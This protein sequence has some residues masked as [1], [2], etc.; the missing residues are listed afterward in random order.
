VENYS[1]MCLQSL[2]LAIQ[3]LFNTYFRTKK[4]LRG[5]MA[6]WVS[7]VETLVQRCKEACQWLVEY[8]SSEEGSTYLKPFLLECPTK[9]TRIAF[10]KMLE[11]TMANFF[12]HGGIPTHKCFDELLEFLLAMLNKD[13]ADNIKN[14]TQYFWVLSMYVQMGTKACSHMF[15]R[16]AFSRLVHFLLG[17][18]SSSTSVNGEQESG[19][20]RWSSIQARD[21]GP[22]HSTIATLILNCDVSPYRTEEPGNHTIYNPTTVVPQRYL[23]MSPEMQS[24]V[25]GTESARYIRE[26]VLALKEVSGSTTHLEDMILYTSF[27]NSTVS[28]SIIRNIMIQCASAPSNELKP[29]FGVLHDML[30]MEDPLQLKRL[31]TVID[32]TTD[33][34]GMLAVI[35]INHMNDS[36]RS[37][38]CIKFL[39]NLANKS[40]LAKDYLMQAPTK[41][42]WAVNWLKKKMTEYYWT[43]S[44]STV[45]SNEDSNS[46]SFQRTISAQDTLAEATAL[47]TEL[48]A[49]DQSDMETNGDS[50]FADDDDNKDEQTEEVEKL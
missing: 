20:R 39:V 35:K 13:V 44:S 41:W 25:F 27:C 37:Y 17:N 8:L 24:Y 48:E 47:L 21:F 32:G 7:G 9:E 38:Q 23:K 28:F 26:V 4:K 22:L 29:L 6:E 11:R 36:R 49:Q 30:V 16:N 46:R 2:K 5:D 15:G 45:Q 40:S 42:Q 10:G 33:C 12:H 43:P 50:A 31:Q 18:N 1:E 19:L 3:F 34:D 14:C